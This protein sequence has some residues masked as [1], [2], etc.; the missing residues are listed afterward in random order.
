MLEVDDRKSKFLHRRDHRAKSLAL[1]S[2]CMISSDMD[3][4]SAFI[5][6]HYKWSCFAA[7]QPQN[8]K[9]VFRCNTKEPLLAITILTFWSL[10][11]VSPSKSKS[12]RNMT[13]AMKPNY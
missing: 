5:N 9:D 13:S 2:K 11:V 7:A 1:R 3:F 12:R 6:A 4:S 8:S 10:Q